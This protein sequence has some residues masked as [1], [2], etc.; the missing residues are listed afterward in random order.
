MTRFTLA[1]Q[2]F[3]GYQRHMCGI[4][5]FVAAPGAKLSTPVMRQMLADFFHLSEPRGQEASGL[6]ISSGDDIRVF[7]RNMSPATMLRNQEFKR[8]LNNSL[9][10]IEFDADGGLKSPVA[11]MGHCRLVTNG[12]EIVPGNNQPVLTKHSVGIHNGIVT[13]DAALWAENPHLNRQFDTDSEILFRLMD[14]GFTTTKNLSA[15]TKD[16]FS[17]I[18]GTASIAYFRND[19]AALGLATN[20]GSLYYRELPESKIFVFASENFILR[21]FLQHQSKALRVAGFETEHLGP[22]EA[23]SVSFDRP[24]AARFSLAPD[25]KAPPEI[26]L[27]PATFQIVDRS[28]RV[29]DIQRCATCVLPATYPFIEF[30]DKGVCQHCRNYKPLDLAGHDA[31]ERALD[32]HRSKDG[33]PDCIVAF[34]GGRDSSY[35]LHLLKTKYEMNPVAYTY[36]WGMVTGIARRNQARILGKLGIEHILRA[37]DIPT[38]RRYMR[39]NILAWLKNPHLGMVPLFMAGDKFFYDIGRDL[40]KELNLDLVIFCAGNELERT[41]FKGGFAGIRESQHGQRLFAFS[42]WNKV[43]IALFYAFQYVRNPAYINESLFDSLHAF[44]SSFINK[45]DFLYLFHYLDWDE[46]VI[47]RTLIGEYGWETA[48]HTENTWRI[49][50]GYTSFI[51]YI[52]YTIAGFSEF[53]TFRSNQIRKGLMSRKDAL[54]LVEQEN[55]PNLDVLYAFAQQTGINLEEVLTKINTIKK[56]Y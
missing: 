43:S 22:G 6:A 55:Q 21:T 35:G 2:P 42:L 41:D 24:K 47:D 20:I 29:A 27:N 18:T 45:D 9:K 38:K 16:V 40:R 48:E 5:G 36:D 17:K 10:D 51:N 50:D 31:L 56:L 7:K 28:N 25:Q 23:C 4:F 13:N 37:A 26:K 15:T 46:K 19:V 1:R 44:R 30:D 3:L 32:K 11:M 49:G 33:S 54:A 8:F 14:D 12:V 52:F 34:S 39:K 53:D